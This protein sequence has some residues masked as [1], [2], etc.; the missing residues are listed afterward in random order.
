MFFK[1]FLALLLFV[2]VLSILLSTVLKKHEIIKMWSNN[3]FVQYILVIKKHYI[4]YKQAYSSQA[5]F[6]QA[7]GAWGREDYG[8]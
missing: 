8:K 4:K 1:K 7:G 3:Q 5:V 6:I 2:Y